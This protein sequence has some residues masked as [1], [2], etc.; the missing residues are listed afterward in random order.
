MLH[1]PRRV[2][3]VRRWLS[4]PAPRSIASSVAHMTTNDV[5][6]AS[7]IIILEPRKWMSAGRPTPRAECPPTSAE[8]M[9]IL[10]RRRQGKIEEW[11]A[12]THLPTVGR[13]PSDTIFSRGTATSGDEGRQRLWPSAAD[14][15]HSRAAQRHKLQRRNQR[16]EARLKGATARARG[17]MTPCSPHDSTTPRGV[18]HAADLVELQH[19]PRLVCGHRRRRQEAAAA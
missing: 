9:L 12:G 5:A 17:G 2:G 18:V 13:H 16:P 19:H 1:Q 11:R 15:E 14:R 7:V 8:C 3:A 10:R 6:A 4:K